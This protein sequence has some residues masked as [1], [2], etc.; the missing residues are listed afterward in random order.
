MRYRFIRDHAT[1]YPVTVLCQTLHVTRSRYYAW[2]RCPES[3]RT[4]DDRHLLTQIQ[5]IYAASHA[6]YGSPRI[7]AALRQQGATCGRHRVVRLMQAQGLRAK[8]RRTFRTT[9]NAHHAL[10]V[11][12]N[13]LDRQFLPAKP[14]QVWVSDIT[15]VPTGE[16]WLYLAAVMDLAFRGIVG[17]AMSD[18]I[19]QTLA[20]DALRDALHRRQPAPGLVHHSDRGVQY[21]GTAYQTVL[22]AHGLLPSMSRR[23]NCWDN[24]PMESFFHS[25]KV[26]WLH[27]QTFRTR[28]EARQAIF[29]FIEVWYNRQRLHSTLGYRSPAQYERTIAA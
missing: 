20:C 22:R 18:R 24:A 23:G 29:T 14:N 2:R 15:Y 4:Q 7:Q 27:E 13:V 10:P 16:G 3:V 26:E 17:W 11:A 21:A 19:D 6:T 9:T 25:L 1:R 5:T 12:A 8:H 28:A